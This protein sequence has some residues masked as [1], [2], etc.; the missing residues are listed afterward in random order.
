MN[1]WQTLIPILMQV[2]EAWF[3][4]RQP[5]AFGPPPAFGDDGAKAEELATQLEGVLA[6]APKGADPAAYGH[7]GGVI[8]HVQ[9][10]ILALR[11][12]DWSK[13]GDVLRDLLSHL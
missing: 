7:E 13:I 6:T 10:L 1:W 3:R 11:S 9:E 2:V 8:Q 4:R 12:G 5:A